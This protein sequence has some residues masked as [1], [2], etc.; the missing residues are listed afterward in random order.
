MQATA[1]ATETVPFLDLKTMHAP[2]MTDIRREIDGVIESHAF[3]LGP[4]VEKFEQSF[5]TCCGVEHC[6]GLNSGTSAVH[7]ALLC[8]GVQPGDE[9]ITTPS[10][11][12]STS[13]AISYIGATPVF[14]DID[15]QTYCLDA[16]QVE[17]AVTPK[18]K[19]IMPVHLYGHPADME[20]LVKL[21]RQFKL[22]VI[23]DAAQAHGARY[24]R[25]ACGS[26]GDIAS[27]SFYPGKN[28]GAFGEAGAVV[29]D[30]AEWAER[31]R[32]LRDHAQAGRH[33]HTE[34]GFNFRMDGLQAAVLNVKLRRLDEWNHRRRRVA[35]WYGQLLRG[36]PG[37]IVPTPAEWAEPVWHIYA[38]QHDQRDALRA[39]LNEHNIQSG[40]HYPTP[41]HLQPAYEHLRYRRGAFPEAEALASRQIS[42]PMFPDMTEDQVT[43]VAEA[44]R[45][46]S[47]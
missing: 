25:R 1:I 15:P 28:L 42:L 36:M 24:D 14:V 22:A 16:A 31:A 19:A 41:I 10:T 33:N 6:V 13:W 3:A 7:V 39:H 18:T 45:A 29:T 27:F 38:A 23:E 43:R 12:I 32:A 9:V 8:A 20:P 26:L 4:A 40:V 11:W 47:V 44:I 37:L 35:E 21:A 34:L 30:N 2:L 46:F 17:Q 5:A